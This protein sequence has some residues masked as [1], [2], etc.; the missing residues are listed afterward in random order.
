MIA[1][2]CDADVATRDDR[3]GAA[4]SPAAVGRRVRQRATFDVIHSHLDVWTLPF[5]QIQPRRR[6]S[7]CMAVSISIMCAQRCRCIRTY[8][9][10]PATARRPRSAAYRDAPRR[11]D[12]YLAFVGRFHPEKGPA[13]AVEIAGR[14]GQPLHVAAKIDPFDIDYYR[15]DIEP[16]FTGFICDDVDEMVKAV[17]LADQLD[18]AACRRNAATFDAAAMRRGYER[19]YQTIC[20]ATIDDRASNLAETL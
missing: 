20:A 13:L 17:D 3:R 4:P 7:Q 6:S 5:A 2:L 1:A 12:G 10:C 8:R 19:V 14:S 11:N 18:P 15:S 9:W 16:L